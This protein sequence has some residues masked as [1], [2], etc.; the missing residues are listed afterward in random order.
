[1]SS[2]SL[3]VP[4][5][6]LEGMQTSPR[7]ERKM[8]YIHDWVCEKT[9]RICAV[10]G[11]DTPDNMTKL[12]EEQ[13]PFAVLIEQIKK[14]GDS[15]EAW[16]NM[17]HLLYTEQLYEQAINA[18][19]KVLSIAP[20]EAN[21]LY[22]VWR[23]FF[24]L[25]NYPEAL[26]YYKQAEKANIFDETIQRSVCQTYV[27][28]WTYTEEAIPY[29]E[30]AI[31]NKPSLEYWMELNYALWRSYQ[32]CGRDLSSMAIYRQLTKQDP[33]FR[34]VKERSNPNILQR[35]KTWFRDMF[36]WNLTK[37]R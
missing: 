12:T 25:E 34:D 33:N 37:P 24:A 5:S 17:G 35:S 30:K 10:L 36:S 3:A 11:I 4:F 8:E 32:K 31:Q 6:G 27:Q 9:D 1:M 28:L 15:A 20:N 22:S 23:C 13:H 21:V 29:Y 16:N 26:K 14:N 2:A 7:S 19:Q 18:Y